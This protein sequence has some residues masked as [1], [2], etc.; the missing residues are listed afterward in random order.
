LLEKGLV[1]LGLYRLAGASDNYYSYVYSNPFLNRKT[2]LI[3]TQKDRVFVLGK[4]IPKELI[5]DY[6]IKSKNKPDPNGIQ[7]DAKKYGKD[8]TPTNKNKDFYGN[9]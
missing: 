1:S 4:D 9:K 2:K 7:E 8:G 6:S 3:V 5:I